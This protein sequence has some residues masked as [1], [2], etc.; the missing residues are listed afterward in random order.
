[1]IVIEAEGEIK[2]NLLRREEEKLF[3]GY[4]TEVMASTVI[5]V[6]RVYL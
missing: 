2:V 6:K 1:M 3:P 5:L 4:R